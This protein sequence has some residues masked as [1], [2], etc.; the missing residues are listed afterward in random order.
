[1]EIRAD[2]AARPASFVAALAV[3]A[4]ARHDAAE[5]L[6][7]GI[8]PSPARVVL[9]AGERV[10]HARLELALEEHVSDHSRVAR[11]GLEREEADARHVLAVEAAVA[12]PEQLVAA[13]DREERGA[14]GRG[15][16]QPLRFRGEVGGDEELLAI[17]SAPR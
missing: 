11:H 14:A 3:V 10:P 7:A 1:M 9:E 16:L 12:A 4:V 6:G 5:R 2:D 8:E 13:A 17:L 15:L